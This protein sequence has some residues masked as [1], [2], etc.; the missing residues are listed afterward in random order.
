MEEEPLATAVL[1]Y[2]QDTS[3]KIR[4][5]LKQ[6]GIRAAF[7]TSSTLGCLLTKVKD[8]VPQEERVVVCTGLTVG[9]ETTTLEKQADH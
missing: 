4:S 5:I 7:Q 6:Y 3:E 1:P 9:V 8:P 2:Y